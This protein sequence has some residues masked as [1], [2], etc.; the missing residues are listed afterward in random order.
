MQLSN[1]YVKMLI[2]K[3]KEKNEIKNEYAIFSKMT[4]KNFI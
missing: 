1:N 3:L 4:L 2:E